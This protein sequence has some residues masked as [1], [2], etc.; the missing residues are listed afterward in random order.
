MGR[1]KQIVKAVKFFVARGVSIN[2]TGYFPDLKGS[3]AGLGFGGKSFVSI[4]A[5]GIVEPP[6]SATD[7]KR[8]GEHVAADSNVLLTGEYRYTVYEPSLEELMRVWDSEVQPM[9]QKGYKA[10]TSNLGE[11]Q[12]IKPIV[13]DGYERGAYTCTYRPTCVTSKP[14]FSMGVMDEVTLFTVKPHSDLFDRFCKDVD[15]MLYDLNDGR[16]LRHCIKTVTDSKEG[17][18]SFNAVLKVSDGEI[19]FLERAIINM[20]TDNGYSI[21]VN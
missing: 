7:V 14:Q 17:K 10:H 20:A 2:F 15:S 9:L 21:V 19:Q 18:V 13:T 1:N 12:L 8:Y 5:D 16:G 3:V 6:V 11:Y 4:Q